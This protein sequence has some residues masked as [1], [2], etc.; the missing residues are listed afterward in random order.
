MGKLS[1]T[2][3]APL[4]VTLGN[5]LLYFLKSLLE[6]NRRFKVKVKCPECHKDINV[7][8]V[9]SDGLFTLRVSKCVV[10]SIQSNMDFSR[11]E[12]LPSTDHY[13]MCECRHTRHEHWWGTKGTDRLTDGQLGTR[14]LMKSYEK[15]LNADVS[16][17]SLDAPVDC[18]CF[19]FKAMSKKT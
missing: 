19:I 9:E 2:K 4:R 11:R 8:V 17:L 18:G 16:I 15:D 13:Q 14:C 7:G 5:T 1:S 6:G 3:L 12:E 10:K